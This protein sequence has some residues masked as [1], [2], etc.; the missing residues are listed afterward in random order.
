MMTIPFQ[1]IHFATYEYFR[2]TLNPSGAYDPK[3]HI[4]SGAVAGAAA[5]AITNPLDVAKTLLQ[6]RGAVAD[7]KVRQASGLLEAFRLIYQKNGMTGF[8][9]GAR[10]RILSHMPATAICWT[11]V[12]VQNPQ[13]QSV[14]IVH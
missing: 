7:T 11:T 12:G 14:F 4:I 10:A 5:A 3:T 9:M 6:T 13:L 1:S 2:K 8:T